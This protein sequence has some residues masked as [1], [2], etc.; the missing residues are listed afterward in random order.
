VYVPP[1]ESRVVRVPSPSGNSPRQLLRLQG[2]SHSFDNKLY[3]ADQ[4][5]D[6]I[7][8]EYIGADRGDDPNGLLYYLE[9]VFG[10]SPRRQM[11]IHSHLPS[12]AFDSDPKDPPRLVIVTAE[13]PQNVSRLRDYLRGGG[14]ILCVATA[15]G[16]AVT[17]AGLAEVSPWEIDESASGAELM[18]GEIAF[19]HPLFAPFAGAQ[20]NDFTKIRFKKHRLI[21]PDRLT[22]SQVLARFEN[23]D[24]AVIE[25][26]IDHGRLVVMAS[27][28]HPADSQL[29]R[30]SKFV[31]LMT[32]LLDDRNPRPEA[33]SKV[34]GEPVPLPAVDESVKSVI[35]HKPDGTTV[36]VFAP[37][38]VFDATD[39]PGIYS[40]DTP[41]GPTWFAVNL[42]PLE[43]KTSPLPVETI[44]HY[45]IRLAN[46]SPK[47]LDREQRR[48][49]YNA[50]LEN[51]QKLWRWLILAAIGILILETW[52][53][54]R[55]IDRP[56]LIRAEALPT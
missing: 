16:R 4:L 13:T 23:N 26:T 17:L 35:V 2:D 51:R 12:Q 42:D 10:D 21:D 50:E 15:P 48:Q 14:T 45:G 9:R 54:G 3:F 38:P 47:T 34:V 29:A 39:Q 33:F 44:E 31:P 46:H 56:R 49:M 25:N 32:A 8:V 37:K 22:G 11:R 5:R 30:S 19:H 40:V 52:L 24:A 27:G 55:A 7:T 43:S 41:A 28:W 53:A 36:T 6:E 18:L 20:F 1:G